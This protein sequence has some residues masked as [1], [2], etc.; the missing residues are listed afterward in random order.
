LKLFL[1]TTVAAAA[2]IAAAAAA[3]LGLLHASLPQL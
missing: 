1:A 2:N 3:A